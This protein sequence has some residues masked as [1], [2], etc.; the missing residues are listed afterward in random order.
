MRY[1]LFLLLLNSWCFGNQSDSSP[2]P[3]I[4]M[5]EEPEENTPIIIDDESESRQCP[6][7]H[8]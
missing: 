1:L 2:D 5:T 3:S 6:C 8:T 7:A 4:L